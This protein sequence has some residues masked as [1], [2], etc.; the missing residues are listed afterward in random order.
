[1]AI[2]IQIRR[3]TA[4][5]WSS[6]NPTLAN[7][8]LGFVTDTTQLKIGNGSTAWNSLPYFLN[9]ASATTAEIAAAVANLIDLSPETLNTLNELAAAIGDDANFATTIN[10][11]ILSASAYA[12]SQANAYADGLTTTDIAE[13]TNLYFTNQR[14]IDAASATYILQTSEQGI[15]NSASAAAAS[16]A[17]GL[18]PNYDSVGSASAAVNTHNLLVTGVHGV[19]GSVVGTSDTQTLTNKT[20]DG[21]SNTISNIANSSLVN[22]SV[23]INDFRVYLGSSASYSTDQIQEGTS[24][25]YF[26]SQR[27]I[28]SGSAT[29]ILQTSQQG[30]IN[31]ASAAA[32]SYADGA[33]TNL[34]DSAPGAL[35][36]LNE[37]A[38]ALGDDENF[39]S[40]IVN[41]ISSASANSISSANSYTDTEV[42][43]AIVT[44]S[45][46][47][48]AY[49]DGLTTTDIVEGTNLYFTDQ[50]AIDAASATYI[51]QTSEQGIINSASAAA[52]T[53]ANSYT[54]TEVAEAIVTASAAAVAYADGLTTTDIAEG[55]NLYYTNTRGLETASTAFVHANHIGLSATY[56][57]GEIRF[58]V[59][60]IDG[61][62]V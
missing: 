16:Y 11:N 58:T 50:R 52:V 31:T 55:T 47:A 56:T 13:G 7:G 2:Q 39:A 34:I 1:M 59:T 19:S 22:D 14:S 24:N 57:G 36:T 41:V 33:I 17:D 20:I 49:A 60:A 8:E 23:W 12:L 44:A 37:L 26:T 42:A 25:L 61:G 38:A 45:A 29:Y 30:I 15:I 40:T 35:N 5:N 28:D 48:V 51:L 27:A 62:G 18:A 10:S 53:S 32:A 43:E 4:T 54:D 46:A 9:S 3:D 6:N 21:S